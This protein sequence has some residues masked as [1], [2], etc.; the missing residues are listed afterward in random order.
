MSGYG[1]RR[2]G[3]PKA[4]LNLVSWE[5]STF[6]Q[7]KVLWKFMRD[8]AQVFEDSPKRL[9]YAHD[10]KGF[11]VEH[12]RPYKVDWFVMVAS[13]VPCL[14]EIAFNDPPLAAQAKLVATSLKPV[15]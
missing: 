11:V 12:D 2:L 15:K 3:A 13:K 8:P 10:P 4:F 14:V 5:G 1:S 6:D 9:W 7:A